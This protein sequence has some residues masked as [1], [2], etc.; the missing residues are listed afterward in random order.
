LT[1]PL[2]AA[3]PG[4]NDLLEQTI[5]RRFA[6]IAAG[7]ERQLQPPAQGYEDLWRFSRRK[8]IEVSAQIRHTMHLPLTTDEQLG[9]KLE[10]RTRTREPEREEERTR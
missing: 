7:R 9:R 3:V 8:S 6:Y 4:L 2:V 5:H 1:A 10:E